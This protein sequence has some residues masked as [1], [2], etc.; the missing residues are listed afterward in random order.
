MGWCHH[1]LGSLS[2]PLSVCLSGCRSVCLS[3][4]LSVKT[5]SQWKTAHRQWGRRGRG[6]DSVGVD[7]VGVTMG[8][9][10]FHHP[11]LYVCRSVCLSIALSVKTCSQWRTAHRLCGRGRDSVDVDWVGVTMGWVHFHH[12]SLSVCLAVGLSVCLLHCL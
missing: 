6:R 5:C 3:I 12:P 2:P 4:A 9:V 1:G 11:S 7:W 10:H 8:W